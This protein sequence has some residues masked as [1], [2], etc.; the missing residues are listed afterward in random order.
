DKDLTRL[1][2]ESSRQQGV[3]LFIA[4]LAIFKLLLFRYTGQDHIVVGTPIANRTRT[5]TEGLIGL[6]VNTLA[7]G[8]RLNGGMTFQSLLDEVRETVLGAHTHKDLPI[9]ILIEELQVERTRSRTPLFQ[10]M[11]ALQN[12]ISEERQLTGLN[13]ESLKS[14]N[15]TAKFDLDFSV[16]E[17]PEEL[18]FSI[19]YNTDLFD[20]ARIE[21]MLA[22]YRSLLEFA[23][24]NPQQ[25]IGQLPLL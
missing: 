12:L 4:L 23:V 15:K 22:H 7:L 24:S 18:R 6:F 2:R 8:T 14:E 10:V 5:E 21:R 20:V 9:E 3:T 1:V 11:F 25:A 17:R 13:L 19:R 16:M